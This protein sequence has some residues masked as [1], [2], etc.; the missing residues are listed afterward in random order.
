M[1]PAL[2][3]FCATAQKLIRALKARGHE[4]LAIAA[5]H[6]SGEVAALHHLGGEHRTFDPKPPGM[7]IFA[8]RRVVQ[9]VRETARSVAGG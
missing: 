6:L 1:A 8:N 4:V 5:S 2:A 9:A 3:V 7:A